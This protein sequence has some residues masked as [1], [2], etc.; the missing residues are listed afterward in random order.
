MKAIKRFSLGGDS[1][2]GRHV[3]LVA[4]NAVISDSGAVTVDI[5]D[6]LARTD[7]KEQ[8]LAVKRIRE[9]SRRFAMAS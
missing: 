4:K 2:S 6:A 7:V 9:A 5:A 1:K 3:T 8:L